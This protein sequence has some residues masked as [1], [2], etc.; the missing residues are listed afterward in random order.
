MYSVDFGFMSSLSS[1]MNYIKFMGASGN[2][3]RCIYSLW[4][5][6]II[7]IIRAKIILYL[8]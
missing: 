6:R 1:A 8:V 2:I 5:S 3:T 4:D 7:A